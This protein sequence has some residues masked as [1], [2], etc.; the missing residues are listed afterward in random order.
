[1]ASH[2]TAALLGVAVLV[3]SGTAA[4]VLFSVAL[5][6]VPAFVDLPAERYVEVH[7]L[8]GRRYDRV[9]PP[10]VITYT[11]IDVVLAAGVGSGTGWGVGS[12]VGVGV[13][14]GVGA[15]LVTGPAGRVLF[16]IAAALGAGVSL[17]SQFG[18]VPINRRVKRMPPGPVPAGWPDPRA[19]WRALNLVRTTFAVL[20]LA[21]N[22][23]ALLLTR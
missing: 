16:G 17:V 22:A 20:G 9:M 8:I 1:M 21:V 5:A 13:G 10:M 15:G 19:R 3:A 4:G 7:K 23:A 6:V 12:G 2:T 18:N 11:L 14:A